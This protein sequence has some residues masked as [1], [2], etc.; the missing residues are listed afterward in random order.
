LLQTKAS[1]CAAVYGRENRLKV[2]RDEQKAEA[3]QYEKDAL[4]KKAESEYRHNLLLKRAHHRFGTTESSGEPPED[5]KEATECL[6]A[7]SEGAGELVPAAAQAVAERDN[8]GAFDSLGFLQTRDPKVQ[9]PEVALE[10]RKAAAKRGEE[11]TQT[12]DARF[13][14]QFAFGHGLAGAAHQPWY[15]KPVSEVA[16]K[17]VAASE[18][19]ALQGAPEP[20]PSKPKKH[21]KEKRH[22]KEKKGKEKTRSKEG[23]VSK[24]R[25]DLFATLRAEREVR[26]AVERKR[27][28]KAVLDANGSASGE[29]KGKRYHSAYGFQ[30][31]AQTARPPH[32]KPS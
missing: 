2:K 14:A 28:R 17:P 30:P 31:P 22:H 8:G 13:D 29:P 12:S 20:A 32:R 18:G 26:E 7:G 5:A 19:L 25:K 1:R 15:A 6:P 9:H 27:A 3:E 23:G 10:Q 4:H 11:K 21:K 24:P 16:G